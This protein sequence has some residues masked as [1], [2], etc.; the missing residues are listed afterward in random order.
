MEATA[1]NSTTEPLRAQHSSVDT[2]RS[3]H[4]NPKRRINRP[5]RSNRQAADI[6]PPTREQSARN[7]GDGSQAR[8]PPADD[9]PAGPGPSNKMPRSINSSQP[10][11]THRGKTSNAPSSMTAAVGGNNGG[12]S[13][14]AP[15]L[16]SGRRGAKFSGGLTDPSSAN[17]ISAP[18][19]LP[20]KKHRNAG[21]EHDDLASTLIYALRTPPYPD[22]PICF[23]PIHPGQPTWSCS[24][25]IPISSGADTDDQKGNDNGQCCWTTFHVKCIREWARKSVKE[26]EDALRARGEN[27]RGE[28]RCPGCQAKRE[29]IPSGYWCV[30]DF[31]NFFPPTIHSLC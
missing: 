9:T 17:S 19:S 5:S 18:S 12:T 1:P 26:V 15:N 13:R 8:N 30:I 10:N 6:A 31:P 20:P 11:A 24:P 14:P 23:S 28:W 29:D 25:S 16:R 7:R 3:N 22:C 4:S 27:R 2:T 21:P